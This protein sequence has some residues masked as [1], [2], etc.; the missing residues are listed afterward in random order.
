MCVGCKITD[1]KAL[2]PQHDR[3]TLQFSEDCLSSGPAFI[4]E[5]PL[6]APLPD[7]DCA[8]TAEASLLTLTPKT[9]LSLFP[10]EP[11]FAS[12]SPSYHT[13]SECCPTVA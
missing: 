8:P 11:L 4:T 5:T 10:P 13:C 3:P 12:G 7:W 1:C 9:D 2:H 6:T